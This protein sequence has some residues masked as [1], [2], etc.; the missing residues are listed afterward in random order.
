M[1]LL[2]DRLKV[3]SAV[4]L[5]VS[6]ATSP[7]GVA[8][9]Q[10]GRVIEE[11]IITAQKTAQ[12]IQDVPISVTAIGGDFMRDAGLSSLQEMSVYV[13][14]IRM[15]T[16]DPGSPQIF[17]RGFGTNTFNPSFEPS[18]GLVQDEVF[19]GRA[20][21]FTEAMFDIERV[22][23]L[24]GPQGTLFGKNTV[25]GVFNIAS[26]GVGEEWSGDIE[27]RQGEHDQRHY[28][29]GLGGMVSDRF[30]LRL[31]ALKTATDGQLYNTT[32]DDTAEASSQEAQRLRLRWLPTD[33][34]DID[35]I[36]V[37]SRSAM[38][39]WPKQL[40]ALDTDTRD[41]LRD[42]DPDIEDDAFDFQTSMDFPG[43]LTKGS[44]TVSAIFNA[45]LGDVGPMR[46][47][48][49]TLVLADT[50]LRVEQIQDLDVSPSDIARL[51]NL[52]RYEQ[53][54]VEWRFTG[55]LDSL[56]GFGNGVQFVAG[57]F[58][59]ES[60]YQL[61]A[62]VDAG[63][64]LVTYLGTADAAQLASG[65]PS[66]PNPGA[67][68]LLNAIN[69]L[70]GGSVIGE[71]YYRFDYDQN[72]QALAFFGQMSISLGDQWVL[73]PGIRY[74]RETKDISTLG[75]AVCDLEAA[76]GTCVMENLLGANDYGPL[77][78]K[79]RKT[80]VSP[81]LSLMYYANEDSNVFLTWSK[82]FKSGGFN[83]ISF[84]GEDLEFED[85]NA[86]TLEIGTK[87]KYFDGSVSINAT[88]YRTEFENLQV[89]AFNGVFFDVAN[90]GAA[91]S[92][93]FEMDWQWLA[94]WQP[95]TLRG[96]LGWLDARYE[97]YPGAPAPISQG[98]GAEQ[99]L[100]DERIAYAPRTTATLS[101]ELLFTLPAAMDLTVALD[102]IHQGEQFTDTDLDPITRVPS[103]N[104]FNLRAA[105]GGNLGASGGS[106]RLTLAVK[107]VLDRRVQNQVVD[108]VFFPGT[109]YAQQKPGRGAYLGLRVSY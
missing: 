98:I 49:S 37:H 67:G 20:A 6:A 93:G 54:S 105:L 56:W 96:S 69:G 64:D 34:L 14:N 57:V 35:L 108:S 66:A 63:D 25:A 42:F 71:D 32:L 40:A 101:P 82:G 18:V 48:V 89:L 3:G 87:G 28:E 12:S 84:T 38:D 68:A 19:F 1:R 45:D 102:M 53:Q 75:E 52:E 65:D 9:Q 22:E 62:S 85:E 58:V 100:S 55:D 59:F 60:D 61:N 76:L 10:Q 26:R 99:D 11:V 2:T 80:D 36:G 23:V 90:A 41:Y 13:P 73:T 46:Q 95:L 92:Q 17:I 72:T 5:C 78:R 7:A 83:S 86:Q 91:Y 16:N 81:K 51:Q 107:N 106:W 97:S 33:W 30:G 24:R 31:S 70:G 39:Y 50:R 47:L 4:L 109:F 79:R 8:Q 104:I 44:D 77:L 27:A 29:G 103:H 43:W 88:A 74:N 21:Y 15:D 94:P